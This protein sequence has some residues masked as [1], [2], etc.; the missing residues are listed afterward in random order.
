MYQFQVNYRDKC[1]QFYVQSEIKGYSGVVEQII[2]NINTLFG[3]VFQI[4]YLNDENAWITLSE[5]DK[6]I[7]DLFRCSRIVPFADFRQIK[8]KIE[9]CS[10]APTPTL[11]STKSWQRTTG[12][13][14]SP[15]KHPKR[16]SFEHVEDNL[17]AG[18]T[19]YK[20]PIKLD[21]DWKKSE[22]SCK[23]EQLEYYDTEYDKLV[24]WY[25]NSRS[26]KQ[27]KQGGK[28]HLFQGHRKN[29]CPNDCCVS[30]IMCGDVSKHLEE[31]TEL[32]DLM[33]KKK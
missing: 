7:K 29:N 1:R 11:D 19:D 15:A 31:N 18:I 25:T 21:I 12:K 13:S 17:Y 14:P 23:E 26:T 5:N 27:G 4:Q 24:S 2:S 22:I 16:L 20:S 9:G 33:E 30:A 3:V 28:C 6:D 8:V 10:P 32:R